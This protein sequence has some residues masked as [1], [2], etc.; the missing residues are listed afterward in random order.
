MVGISNVAIEEFIEKENDDFQRNFF[1]F[2]LSDRA[3][4]FLNFLKMMKRRGGH[5]PFAILNTDRS[6]LSG[7]HWWSKHIPKRSNCFYS[8]L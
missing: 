4:P 8:I 1:F 3:T 6:N 2:F 5:Y 7:T